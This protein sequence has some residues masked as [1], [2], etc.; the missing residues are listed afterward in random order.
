MLM[1]TVTP[2]QQKQLRI[3]PGHATMDYIGG[4]ADNHI[5][6]MSV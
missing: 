3:M 6:T 5:P 1:V 4:W 2:Q